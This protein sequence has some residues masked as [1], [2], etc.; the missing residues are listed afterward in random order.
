MTIPEDDSCGAIE[1]TVD[2][3]GCVKLKAP[4]LEEIHLSPWQMREL[5]AWWQRREQGEETI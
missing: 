3:G 1:V 4:S 2:I 5:V